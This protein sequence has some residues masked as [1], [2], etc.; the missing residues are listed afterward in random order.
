MIDS[1]RARAAA[2]YQPY[3]GPLA[4][5][6]NLTEARVADPQGQRHRDVALAKVSLEL[7]KVSLEGA[8]AEFANPCRALNAVGAEAGC[9][10]AR[11]RGACT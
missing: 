2:G 8:E 4:P 9:G 7:A 5:P 3:E 1:L 10:M 11:G 6:S